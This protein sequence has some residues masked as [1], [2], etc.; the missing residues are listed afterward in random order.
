[1]KDVFSGSRN[2]WRSIQLDWI[3]TFIYWVIISVETVAAC[4]MWFGFSTMLS[5]RH[6]DE[7][8]FSKASQ[9]A[10]NGII[11]ACVLWLTGF[12]T[13]AGEWF[14]MYQSEVWNAQATA[15]SL[16]VSYMMVL[17]YLEKNSS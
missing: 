4:L 5:A 8:K 3:Q 6:E 14:L 7:V 16:F 2:V 17:L 1:M 11:L 15:F 13:I 12:L 10:A 9:L